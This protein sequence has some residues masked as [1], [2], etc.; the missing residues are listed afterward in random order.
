VSNDELSGRILCLDLGEKRIGVAL[1]DETR[2]I[3]RSYLV[4]ERSSRAND[5]K[6]IAG[7]AEQKGVSLVIVGLPTL[8]DGG[9][10]EKAAW[11]RDYA[12]DLAGSI[13]IQVELWDESYSTV[14]AQEN[15]RLR[16]TS[17]RRKKELI[18]AVAAAFILQSYLDA[19]ASSWQKS[20][21]PED[22]A[23][24]KI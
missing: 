24:A 5:F 2:T 15:L 10:G 6:R 7:I 17:R 8:A 3:A 4:F 1:S 20:P 11:A 23:E 9:E 19:Q 14:D 13:G 22:S 21:D 12:F 18:D 16:G